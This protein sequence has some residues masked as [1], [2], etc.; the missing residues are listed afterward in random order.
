MSVLPKGT[1]SPSANIKP[2]LKGTRTPKQLENAR[3]E[4]AEALRLLE[5]E[6]GNSQDHAVLLAYYRG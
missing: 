5:I 3:I 4:V 1:F 2:E 6:A